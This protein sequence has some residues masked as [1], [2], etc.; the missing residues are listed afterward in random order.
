MVCSEK[1]DLKPVAASKVEQIT[2]QLQTPDGKPAFDPVE[3]IKSG[4]IKF[5]K[6]KYE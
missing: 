4:Y 5:K 6:E 2:S 1:G 3:R